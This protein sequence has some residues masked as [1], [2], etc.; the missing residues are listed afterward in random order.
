MMAHT[1]HALTRSATGVSLLSEAYGNIKREISTEK[2]VVDGA[3]H[4]AF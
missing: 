3:R 1:T 2:S 4:G